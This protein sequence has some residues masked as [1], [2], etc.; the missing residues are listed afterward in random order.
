MIHATSG[1]VAAFLAESASQALVGEKS[2][3]VVEVF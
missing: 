3:E 2:L 1:D